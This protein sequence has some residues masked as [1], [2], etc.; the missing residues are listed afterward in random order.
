MNRFAS[1][2]IEYPNEKFS[3]IARDSYASPR[4]FEIMESL[5]LSIVGGVARKDIQYVRLGY[6]DEYPAGFLQELRVLHN[7]K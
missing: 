3:V 7:N 2:E 6:C 1:I 4:L 5:K